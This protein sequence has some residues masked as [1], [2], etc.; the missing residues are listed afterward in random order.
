MPSKKV[1]TAC[2]AS[3]CGAF[4]NFALAFIKIYIGL[5]A[6]S[7]SIMSDGI[8]NIGDVLG[9]SA[10]AAGIAVSEKKPSW[11]YPF[12]YGRIEYIAAMFISAVIVIVGGVFL[13]QS[14][15]RLF[16]HPPVAFSPMYCYIIAATVVVKAGLG[17]M[18]HFAAKST[19]STVMRSERLDSTMD[20]IITTLTLAALIIQIYTSIPVDA[21]AGVII[22]AI[23]ITEGIKLVTDAFKKLSGERDDETEKNLR[24][25]IKSFKEVK[26]VVKIDI[27]R[28]GENSIYAVAVI[29]FDR[30]M[31]LIDATKICEKIKEEARKTSNIA[32]NIEIRSGIYE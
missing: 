6:S 8:N 20:A 13:W 21:I 16:F 25:L 19:G 30:N 11:R 23:V 2:V 24:S 27:H 9:C 29:F 22:S 17:L 10:A 7:V 1:K 26:E 28:Y 18:F 12:G 32:L 3:I 15:D 5:A 14:I 31:T 4:V